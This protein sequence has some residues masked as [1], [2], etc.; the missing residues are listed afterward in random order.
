V[1]PSEA[2]GHAVRG[3]AVQVRP[4]LQPF[5]FFAFLIHIWGRR[6]HRSHQKHEESEIEK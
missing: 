3:S 1:R 2:M 4:D 6:E 5:I